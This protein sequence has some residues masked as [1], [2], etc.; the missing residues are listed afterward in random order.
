M[1]LGSGVV[2]RGARLQGEILVITGG[3]LFVSTHKTFTIVYS[4]HCDLTLPTISSYGKAH[5]N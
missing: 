3:L 2:G 1:L 5:V 4:I